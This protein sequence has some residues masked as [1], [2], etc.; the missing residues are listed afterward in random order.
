[1]K[2]LNELYLRKLNNTKGSALITVL[3]IITLLTV[4]GTGLM[5]VTVTSFRYTYDLSG[6]NKAFYITDGAIEESLAELNEMVFAAESVANNHIDSV[7]SF[8]NE[9]IFDALEAGEL[10]G[11]FLANDTWRP[12]LLKVKSDLQNE[13]ISE[14]EAMEHIEIGLRCEFLVKYY[15]EFLNTSKSN[16]TYTLQDGD[17]E[18]LGTLDDSETYLSTALDFGS[19][20]SS[21]LNSEALRTLTTVDVKNLV[22]SVA[23]YEGEALDSG[24]ADN[25]PVIK[26]E[27]V[28]SSFTESDGIKVTLRTDGSYNDHQRAIELK[29]KVTEPRYQ[30][31]FK[32]T[33]GTEIIRENELMNY[34]I[35]SGKDLLVSGGPVNVNG[36]VYA[37]GTFPETENVRQKEMGGIMLGYRDETDGYLN[38]DMSG[39]LYESQLTPDGALRVMGSLYTRANVK[40]IQGGN[41]LYVSQN[42]GANEFRTDKYTTGTGDT[43]VTIDGNMYLYEDI[44]LRGSSGDTNIRIGKDGT[45]DGDLYLIQSIGGTE[46]A[47]G[48]M[49]G[50]IIVQKDVAGK[51]KLDLNKLYISGLSYSGISRMDI[52]DGDQ[53]Q[54]YFMTGESVSVENKYMKFYESSHA[55]KNDYADKLGAYE[56]VTYYYGFNEAG[57]PVDAQ[58]NVTTAGYDYVEKYGDSDNVDFKASAF[59]MGATNGDST[60]GSTE[61]DTEDKQMITIRSL[62]EAGD[63]TDNYAIGVV[64]GTNNLGQSGVLNPDYSMA[65]GFHEQSLKQILLNADTANAGRDVDRLMNLLATRDLGSNENDVFNYV[66]PSS[67]TPPNLI[68]SSSSDTRISQMVNFGVNVDEVTNLNNIRVVN[69]NAAKDIYINP[70]GAVDANDLAIGHGISNVIINL[71]GTIATKG[72]VY[73]YAPAAVTVNYNGLITAE[74]RIIFYGPGTKNI[75]LDRSLVEYQIAAYTDMGNAFYADEGRK[76]ENV[77]GYYDG[78]SALEAKFDLS[79]YS[80]PLYT[81]DYGNTPIIAVVPQGDPITVRLDQPPILVGMQKNKGIKGYEIEYWREV[82]D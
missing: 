55:V 4:L 35:T 50:S 73:I 19:I 53:V 39:F 36:H 29:V 23:G 34:A 66:E 1:M 70:P 37:Y 71:G 46:Y 67:T 15:G 56:E 54:R 65:R 28:T 24:S 26:S 13:N 14:E 16:L 18:Y 40:F 22:S 68:Q 51:V 2:L 82:R 20:T 57:Q 44:V 17:G 59:M 7:F 5:M 75:S 49:S 81:V 79:G 63:Y 25:N 33:Q 61:V 42:L 27:N 6:A 72:D 77:G 45:T 47:S 8:T 74:G 9:N 52:K 62:N 58:G 30:F 3:I 31:V 76:I 11:T 21:A 48:D 78:N 64:L 38:N 32:T 10:E 12:F 69:N 41:S 43:T 60:A 80:L